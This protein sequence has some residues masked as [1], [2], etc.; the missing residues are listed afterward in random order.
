MKKYLDVDDGILIF[1]QN[2]SLALWAVAIVNHN[3]TA[4]H[5][6]DDF[7]FSRI[8]VTASIVGLVLSAL[9]LAFHVR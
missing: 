3:N 6:V 2:M 5:A 4:I 9:F 1:L 7:Y 8:N